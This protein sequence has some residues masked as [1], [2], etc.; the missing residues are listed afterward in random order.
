MFKFLHTADVHLDSPLLNLDNYD[1]APREEFR[2]A[3]R[4][5]LDNLVEL[6]IAEQV[7]FVLIAGDL[8]D[9]DCSDFNTP[10]H[11]RRKM[12]ELGEHQIRVFIIQGNHDAASSMRKAF[13]LQLPD[14]VHL[15]RTDKPETVRIDEL[16]VAIH[17]QGFATK[18]VTDDLSKKYPEAISGFV[19]IGMLHTS[20]GVHDK[21]DNYAPSTVKGLQS[22]EY[23]YWALGH[24]HKGQRLAGP[25]PWIIYPGNPQGRHIGETGA[26]SCIVA[27]CDGGDIRLRSHSIDVLRWYRLRTDVSECEDADAAIHTVQ[28]AI[29]QALGNADG[30]P[31]A[32][33]IELE[34]ASEAHDQFVK[35]SDHWDE[36]IRRGVL[37]RFDERVWVEKIKFRTTALVDRSEELDSTFGE[38]IDG[39]RDPDLAESARCSLQIEFE[40]LRSQIP[41]DPRV[42]DEEIDIENAAS[43]TKLVQEAQELLIGRLMDLGGEP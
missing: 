15:F 42:S 12:R 22:K 35:Q 19:N 36:Q 7:H 25:S 3:T 26:K 18:S 9:G 30:L 20:C 21:H 34:G 11:F 38:L 39:I 43:V 41:T 4:R 10:L 40:K 5:A 28:V 33:R 29:D 27:T 32:V 13:S 2:S 17:G 37:D 1:D 16:N 24:I 8:Y 31:I 14:N 23:Q 6:A